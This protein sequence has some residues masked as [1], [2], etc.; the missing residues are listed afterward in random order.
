MK[1]A[2]LDYIRAWAGQP[3]EEALNDLAEAEATARAEAANRAIAAISSAIDHA[4]VQMEQAADD[5]AAEAFRRQLV[6]LEQGIP[7]RRLP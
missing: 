6:L 3:T 7:G 5:D 1:S 4:V 2:R